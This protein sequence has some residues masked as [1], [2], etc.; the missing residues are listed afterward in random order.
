MKKQLSCLLVD[1]L[2]ENRE[3]LRRMVERTGFVATVVEAADGAAA[4]EMIRG[5]RPD[6]VITDIQMPTMDGWELVQWLRDQEQ[7]GRLPVMTVSSMDPEE[8]RSRSARMGVSVVLPRPFL[9][10]EFT[11]A[12]GRLHAQV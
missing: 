2:S 9:L 5:T 4:V 10:E 11:E 3:L 7:Y 1:D 6:M 12:F 8:L